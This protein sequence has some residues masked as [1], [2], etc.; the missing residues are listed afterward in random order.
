MFLVI[1]ISADGKAQAASLSLPDAFSNLK[2]PGPC[3]PDPP[4]FHYYL[5]PISSDTVNT[6]VSI[7]IPTLPSLA[8]SPGSAQN[9]LKDEMEKREEP[10]PSSSYVVILIKRG[11]NPQPY[12]ENALADGA[13]LFQT[14]DK[15]LLCLPGR[16][17]VTQSWPIAM[18]T[19]QAQQFSHL[20]LLNMGSWYVAEASLKLLSSNTSALAS[21]RVRIIGSCPV[22]Q[23]VVQW[24]YL[25]SLQPLPPGFKRFCCLSLPSSWDYRCMPPHP[26]NFC[27]FNR[28]GVSPYWPG[29]SLSPDLVICPPRPPKVLGLQA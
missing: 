12:G 14:P 6:S 25:G 4:F 22:A 9:L 5:N 29:W 11:K 28:D 23:A 7:C 2:A 10:C 13:H 21:Q 20:S 8:A 1:E 27:I 15:F 18:S 26:A 24:Q 16:T 17:A 19:S 3:S